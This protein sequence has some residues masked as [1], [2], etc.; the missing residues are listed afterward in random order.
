MKKSTLRTLIREQIK[1]TLEEEETKPKE[2]ESM[3]IADL[4]NKFSQIG[5]K[6]RGSELKG[7]D[8]SEIKAI[9][10]LLDKILQSVQDENATALLQRLDRMVK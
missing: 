6:M 10:T 3:T 8:Q 4:G 5:K 7:M 1:I 9:S 2:R